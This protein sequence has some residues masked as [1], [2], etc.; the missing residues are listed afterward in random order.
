MA[1]LIVADVPAGIEYNTPSIKW[2]W[3]LFS[4]AS[5]LWWMVSL[6]SVAYSV[7]FLL[8]DCHISIVSHRLIVT[9][10]RTLC[11]PR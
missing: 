8:A 10:F 1:D 5:T 3:W 11:F 6:F 4:I 2:W 9:S 7:F